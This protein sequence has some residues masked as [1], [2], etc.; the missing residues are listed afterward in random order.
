MLSSGLN[1]VVEFFFVAPPQGTAHSFSVFISTL[2][3]KNNSPTNVCP[4]ILVLLAACNR[5]CTSEI[6][7]MLRE[8]GWFG[9]AIKL[10]ESKIDLLVPFPF[11]DIPNHTTIICLI[12]KVGRRSSGHEDPV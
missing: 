11:D 2:Q 3:Y 1:H 5:N 7:K 10:N 9:G 6:I 12:T 8:K 4:A